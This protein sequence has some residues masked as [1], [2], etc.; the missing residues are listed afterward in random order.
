MAKKL[1]GRRGVPITKDILYM[2]RVSLPTHKL[3]VT[4]YMYAEVQ[5]QSIRLQECAGDPIY[6]LLPK[7][8]PN[9]ITTKHTPNTLQDLS[10][11]QHPPQKE[12]HKR[13]YKEKLAPTSVS[14][15]K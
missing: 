4:T 5:V 1:T 3:H 10:S 8:P 13:S 15:K 14:N 12:I 11:L 6:I 9:P 7:M 2:A